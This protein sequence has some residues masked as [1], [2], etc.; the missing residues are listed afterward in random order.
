MALTK[1]GGKWH[2]VFQAD[3]RRYSRSTGLEGTKRNRTEAVRM[4]AEHRQAVREG[5]AF[6]PRLK[7]RTC[8][9]AAAEYLAWCD[10]EHR[11]RPSTARRIR[12]SWATLGQHLGPLMVASVTPADIERFKA[13]RIAEHEVRDVTLRHDLHALSGFYRWA[14]RMGYAADNPVAAVKIPSDREAVRMH[15]LSAEEER[16]YFAAAAKMPDLYDLGR[17]MIQQGLRPDEV[18]HLTAPDVDLAA[19]RATVRRSKTRAGQRTVTLTSESK[20]ILARRIAGLP[21]NCPAE[22]TLWT[23]SPSGLAKMHW[24]ALGRPPK[25]KDGTLRGPNALGFEMC[26][27]DI[28]HTFATRMAQHGC[29]LATLAAIL[30]HGNLRTCQRYIHISAAHQEAAMRKYDISQ[31]AAEKAAAVQ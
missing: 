6:R 18:L 9:D 1:R 11:D 21:P 20:S 19:G 3:G 2:Y 5:R 7:A 17:V 12:T 30:G 24:R 14:L 22:R 26:V 13:W 23:C 28:R 16:L 10:A 27:Y 8:S 15:V 4:E 31:Q 25:P 29:D